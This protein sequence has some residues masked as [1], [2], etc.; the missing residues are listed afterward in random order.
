MPLIG[1]GG[2]RTVGDYDE[3]ASYVHMLGFNSPSNI[4]MSQQMVT[5]IAYGIEYAVLAS[6]GYTPQEAFLAASKT[7]VPYFRVKYNRAS[8][9]F[10]MKAHS[11]AHKGVTSSYTPSVFPNGIGK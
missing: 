6:C 11:I 8:N 9:T 5:D 2:C 7:N 1:P 4:P 3:L 10:N